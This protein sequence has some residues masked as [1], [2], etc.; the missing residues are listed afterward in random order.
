MF[1]SIMIIMIIITIIIMTNIIVIIIIIIII[2]FIMISS[3]SSS[4]SS[5]IIIIM[6]IGINIIIVLV[7]LV[8]IVNNWLCYHMIGIIIVEGGREAS[9]RL[10]RHD[11][12]SSYFFNWDFCR[13]K[14]AILFGK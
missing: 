9:E 13:E 14:D 5:I 6:I 12:S 4:S 7:C 8:G 10:Q 3:S 11:L 1:I 2:M